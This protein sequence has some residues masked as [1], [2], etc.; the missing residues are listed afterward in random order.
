MNS[1]KIHASVNT[2]F[3]PDGN[4]THSEG[5]ERESKKDIERQTKR[6]KHRERGRREAGLLVHYASHFGVTRR[7]KY[8]FLRRRK[9]TEE[10]GRLYG[11]STGWLT[12]S[13]VCFNASRRYLSIY[14]SH[15]T[16]LVSGNNRFPFRPPGFSLSPDALSLSGS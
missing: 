13:I 8:S 1:R 14:L 15:S 2:H 5:R 9:K 10:E 4:C 16:T 12:G 11:E 3:S 7:R 6:E